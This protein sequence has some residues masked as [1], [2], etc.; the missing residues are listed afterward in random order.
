MLHQQGQ[1]GLGE[2]GDIG[3]M[4]AEQV[5]IDVE[6]ALQHLGAPLEALFD[7]GLQ[8]RDLHRRPDGF[9]PR[10]LAQ[11]GPCRKHREHRQ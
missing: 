5:E 2:D 1:G 7:V 11:P 10:N 9:R 3:R 8:Q 6:P 4:V